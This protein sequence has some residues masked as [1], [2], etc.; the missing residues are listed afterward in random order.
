MESNNELKL[1][2]TEYRAESDACKKEKEDSFD[3]CDTDGFLSQ[4]ASG[5]HSSLN[6]RLAELAENDWKWDFWDDGDLCPVESGKLVQSHLCWDC[7]D[8]KIDEEKNDFMNTDQTITRRNNFMKK[9]LTDP[10]QYPSLMDDQFL[11]DVHQYVIDW[12][13]PDKYARGVVAS[14]IVLNGDQG[15]NVLVFQTL[16]IL[17][18]IFVQDEV[19]EN[20]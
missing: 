16:I 15:I 3:R 1:T 6:S 17:S 7:H 18:R 9:V 13:V 20:S 10:N 5:L 2:A 4:W 19:G 12:G 8:D 11:K 14:G